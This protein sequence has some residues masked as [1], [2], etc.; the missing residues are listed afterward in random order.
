MTRV[1]HASRRNRAQLRRNYP[2]W[3]ADCTAT[4]AI[5]ANKLRVTFSAPVMIKGIPA[6]TVNA[7]AATAVAVNSSTEIDLTYAVNVAAG[8]TWLAPAR[9]AGI[10]TGSGGYVAKS[11]GTF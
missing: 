2:A 8:Q 3:G 5:N 4:A 7:A 6:I 9:C 1:V 10:R 11:T